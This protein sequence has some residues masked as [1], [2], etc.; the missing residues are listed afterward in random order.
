M[1]SEPGGDRNIVRPLCW[2]LLAAVL[3]VSIAWRL[4][5]VSVGPDPDTD[6]Y[7][8]YMIARLLWDTPLNFDIHWV[9]LPF[10]HALLALP[11]RLGAT[12][13]QVR[14]ANAVLAALPALLT[15][16][17]LSRPST[18]AGPAARWERILPFV[19]GLLV[20]LD[21]LGMQMGTTGQ[22]E[23][24]FSTLLVLA[25]G[26][27][28]RERFA[29]AAAVLGVLV[30]TR[31]E[32]WAVAAVVGAVLLYRRVSRGAPLGRG[33]LACLFV[34]ALCVLGWAALRRSGGGSWFGFLFDNQA[35]AERVLEHDPP[36]HGVLGALGRYT[37]A[38][39]YRVFGVA[40][41]LVPLG[42]GR[43]A[44]RHGVWLVAP[45]LA[46]VVFLTL[47]SLSR[48]QLGLDR[49]FLSVVPFAAAWVTY[50]I[51]WCGDGIARLLLR[52]GVHESGRGFASLTGAAVAAAVLANAQNGLASSLGPW[53]EATR[54]ALAEPRAAARFLR[55]TAPSSLIFCAEASIEVL[56]ELD[57]RRFVR[58]HVDTRTTPQLS[59][60][61]RTR[62]VYVV[63]RARRLGHL[64]SV[65]RPSHGTADG[66]PDAFVVLYLP[67]TGL[68][69]TGGV[70]TLPQNDFAAAPSDGDIP[71]DSTETRY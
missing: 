56:S 7:G 15:C 46:I 1:S 39:P 52:R 43:T 33:E 44:Q 21:P 9:W 55:T 27:L 69:G 12:L 4:G 19:A 51:A 50:G 37:A 28:T 16:W 34:P 13:D 63:D 38:V 68:A 61:N 48:S 25:V 67:A 31:Y 70:A 66:P 24:F 30:L 20:A 23:I 41:L 11:V 14:S 35:F 40:A 5:C 6:A 71:V 2:C 18:A 32:G 58:A 64:L 17:A 62:D 65:A 47:T 26:L 10:Y 53:K 29:W 42:I 57:R 45:G 36:T 8:H 60:L 54:A 22:M 59:L 49:H 3:L